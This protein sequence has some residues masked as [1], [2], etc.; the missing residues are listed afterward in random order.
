M[1]GFRL[2][3]TQRIPDMDAIADFSELMNVYET[4]FPERSIFAMRQFLLLMPHDG[5]MLEFVLVV[6]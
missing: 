2:E 3:G 4:S 6:P 5:L 1:E